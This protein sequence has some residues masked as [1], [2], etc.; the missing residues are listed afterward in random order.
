[1]RHALECSIP[2]VYG[3]TRVEQGV[4]ESELRKLKNQGIISEHDTKLPDFGPLPPPS[5]A[6]SQGTPE[7]EED[8]AGDDDDDDDEEEDNKRRTR[9]KRTTKREATLD[10]DD[11]GGKKE[12]EQRRKRG[13]PPRV[14]TPMECRIKNIMKGLRKSKDEEYDWV[15]LSNFQDLADCG[16]V[17][18]CG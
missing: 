4:L 2:R 14:D 8:S 15:F 12:T 11:E 1:M 10:D 5:P 18:I 13:R 3:L 9:K 16:K 17:A 6:G 7:P